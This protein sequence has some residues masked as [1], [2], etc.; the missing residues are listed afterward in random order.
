MAKKNIECKDKNCPIHGSLSTRGRSFIGTVTSTKMHKTAT[1]EWV[2]RKH[3]HKYE[4]HEK[5]RSR[6]KAHN[7]ECINAKEGDVVKIRE[8]R[9]LSKTK[10][11]A[12]VESLGQEKGYLM[13]KEAMEEAKIEKPKKELEEE[14]NE[15]SESSDN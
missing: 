10:N 9:P 8:C 7:P 2:Y 6:I 1:V 11:F 4:R 15:S 12:I 3:L 13:K 5:K 14:K